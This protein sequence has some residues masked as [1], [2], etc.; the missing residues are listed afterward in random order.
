MKRN[1]S[2]KLPYAATNAD[3]VEDEV[4]VSSVGSHKNINHA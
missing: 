3:S 2:Q 1:I 4:M